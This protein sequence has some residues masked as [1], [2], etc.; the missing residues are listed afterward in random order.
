MQNFSDN[1]KNLLSK[2][3][4]IAI[5]KSNPNFNYEPVSDLFEIKD[6]GGIIFLVNDPTYQILL[7][8]DY[9]NQYTLGILI[10]QHEVLSTDNN[11]S[12]LNL[13]KK[14]FLKKCSNII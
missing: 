2:L 5:T 11:L 8:K 3:A 9:F 6:M 4:S 10:G 13:Q 12:V 14:I 1:Q 7:Q